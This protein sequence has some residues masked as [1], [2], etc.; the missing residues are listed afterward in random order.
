LQGTGTTIIN[1]TN[2][3][4][5]PIAPPMSATVFFKNPKLTGLDTGLVILQKTW[6]CMLFGRRPTVSSQPTARAGS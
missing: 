1:Y 6:C 4:A 2:T 3:F 5:G